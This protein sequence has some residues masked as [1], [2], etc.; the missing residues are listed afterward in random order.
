MR[1]R[2]LSL[3]CCQLKP[4]IIRQQ[5]TASPLRLTLSF[6]ATTTRF[7]LQEENL[8]L[9]TQKREVSYRRVRSSQFFLLTTSGSLFSLSCRQLDLTELDICSI[10][11]HDV[12]STKEEVDWYRLSA[13]TWC[14]SFQFMAASEQFTIVELC[15]HI[16]KE[17]ETRTS[18]RAPDDL[19]TSIKCQCTHLRMSNSKIIFTICLFSISFSWLNGAVLTHTSSA[20]V[21]ELPRRRQHTA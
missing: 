13:R 3:C 12:S 21:R 6:R 8:N 19:Q 14:V 18:F 5:F 20:H 2:P 16:R 15:V 17:V 11:M 4:I 7:M 1:P 10:S 9:K